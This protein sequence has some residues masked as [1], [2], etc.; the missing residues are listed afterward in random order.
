M[1]GWRAENGRHDIKSIVP[2]FIKGKEHRTLGKRKKGY[3]K[4]GTGGGDYW[5][6]GKDTRWENMGGNGS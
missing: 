3:G 2:G 1:E 4:K 6:A 5:K